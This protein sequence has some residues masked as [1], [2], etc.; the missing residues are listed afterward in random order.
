MDAQAAKYPSLGGSYRCHCLLAMDP[1]TQQVLSYDIVTVN[2]TN[3]SVSL[4]AAKLT[5]TT[6]SDSLV[7]PA[8]SMP[9]YFS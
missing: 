1:F 8:L 4:P 3:S 7:S 9:C 6:V 5:I 2:T